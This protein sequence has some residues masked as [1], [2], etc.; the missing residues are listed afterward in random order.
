MKR[1][2]ALLILL[3]LSS[4][5][6]S[7]GRRP[8]LFTEDATMVPEGDVELEFW[9]DYVNLDVSTS[10]KWR[11]WLGPRW[12]P[13]ERLE[14][15]ALTSWQQLDDGGSGGSSLWAEQFEA[16]LRALTLGQRVSLF[17]IL[18]YRIG[19]APGVQSFLSPQ[20]GVAA[21]LRRFNLA[22]EVGYLFGFRRL[23]APAPDIPVK[24]S[25]PFRAGASYEIIHGELAA[26]VQVGVEIAGERLTEGSLNDVG[27][28]GSAHLSPA[29]VGP[30]V[31][32]AKGRLWATAGVLFPLNQQPTAY[33]RLIIGVAL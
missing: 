10:D 23:R 14:V 20:I 11:M 24:D 29:N 32:V 33:F 9:L 30:T 28:P 25:F 8:F 13:F 22:A 26:P 1:A 2:F 12:A 21:R 5:R 7:A 4:G 31:A 16:R 6:A 19:F 17:G 18:N 27:G 3:I 15:A